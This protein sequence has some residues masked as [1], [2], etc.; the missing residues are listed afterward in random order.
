MLALLAYPDADYPDVIL[1]ESRSMLTLY[2]LGD[3]KLINAYLTKN[4]IQ[5][6]NL[7]KEFLKI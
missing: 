2:W 6:I 1:F 4:S 3:R 5:N 7:Q